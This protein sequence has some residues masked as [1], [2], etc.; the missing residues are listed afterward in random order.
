MRSPRSN[1]TT[2]GYLHRDY[3]EITWFALYGH[4]L[5]PGV[6]H[7]WVAEADV[8]WTGNIASVLAQAAAIQG[9]FLCCLEPGQEEPFPPNPWYW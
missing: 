4:L 9:D 8:G 6:R 2:L 3:P 7:I 1:D 5:K